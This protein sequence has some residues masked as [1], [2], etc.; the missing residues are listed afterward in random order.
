MFTSVLN[1]LS[2]LTYTVMNDKLSFRENFFAMSVTIYGN[3]RFTEPKRKF[4]FSISY[5]NCNHATRE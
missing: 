5:S 3:M 2:T 4:H 1:Q